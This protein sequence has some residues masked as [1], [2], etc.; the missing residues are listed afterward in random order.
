[1]LTAEASV[2]KI[3]SLRKYSHHC[4]THLGFQF[5]FAPVMKIKIPALYSFTTDRL[6]PNKPYS[7]HSAS[8][9][10]LPYSLQFSVIPLSFDSFCLCF[11]HSEASSTQISPPN[12]SVPRTIP[13]LKPTSPVA[14]TPKHLTLSFEIVLCF[15][16]ASRGKNVFGF[17]ATS[18]NHSILRT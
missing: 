18:H 7:S 3:T 10:I 13:S 15:V 16:V 6:P 4:S 1:M 12:L 17:L 11:H 2:P 9:S 5:C 8:Q 14:V